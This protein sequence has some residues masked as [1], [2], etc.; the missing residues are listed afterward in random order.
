MPTLAHDLVDLPVLLSTNKLFVFVGKL[1]LDPDL[2]LGSLDE[3]DLLND[4]HC[5]FD[6]V[7]GTIDG[8]RQLIE[9]DIGAGIGADI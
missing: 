9:T 1:Y 8:E 7:V 3:R 6:G 4:H 2:I 5:S